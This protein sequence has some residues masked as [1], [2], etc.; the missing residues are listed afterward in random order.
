MNCRF[1][2]HDHEDCLNPATRVIEFR[3]KSELTKSGRNEVIY[4]YAC[5]NAVI[6]NSLP[7]YVC[8]ELSTE[9][10]AVFWVHQ[11]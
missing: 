9:E 1:C 6:C 7:S 2:S 5:E 3:L 11:E 10:S 4:N 8:R